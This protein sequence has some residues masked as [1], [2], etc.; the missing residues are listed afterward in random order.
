MQQPYKVEDKFDLQVEY[1]KDSG[2]ENTAYEGDEI[3]R[4]NETQ[5]PENVIVKLSMPVI[6]RF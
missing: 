6:E 5:D 1:I 3:K 2:Q 4:P